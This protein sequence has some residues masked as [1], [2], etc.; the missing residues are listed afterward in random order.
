MSEVSTKKI[1]VPLAGERFS[2]HFGQATAFALFEVDPTQRKIVGQTVLPL[3]GQ[4][5]CGMAGWLR[6][7]G[8]Q[9]VIV[10]GLGRGALANLATAHIDVFAAIAA[11]TPEA[12][13]QACLEGRLQSATASCGNGHEHGKGHALGHGHGHGA[14]HTCQCQATPT[15]N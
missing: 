3:P 10:G 13:V 11:T 7:Q 5:A 12:L 15:A 4:H 9:M 6:E 2:P 1:A 14:G 8:V